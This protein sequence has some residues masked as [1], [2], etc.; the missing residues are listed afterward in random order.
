MTSRRRRIAKGALIAFA[1]LLSA[2]LLRAWIAQQDAPLSCRAAFGPQGEHNGYVQFTLQS[3]HPT[4]ELLEGEIFLYSPA[5]ENPPDHI[6]LTRAA[7]GA[8]ASS[9]LSSP[10]VPWSQGRAFR[11][12]QPF[13]IP[14]PGVSHRQFP[15]DNP[16]LEISVAFDPPLQ[17]KIVVIRN[18]S[19]AFIPV[20]E[21]LVANWRDPA[22]LDLSIQFKRNP[23]VQLSI[24]TVALAALI[25][26]LLL[27]RLRS[28]S[29]LSSAA[30]A[31]FFSVW[32]IRGVAE[33]AIL[34]FPTLL[35]LWLLMCILV[36]LFLLAWRAVSSR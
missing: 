5:T 2:C 34:S 19:G 22:T 30:A 32:S 17:P 12:P 10:L 31:Y 9:T 1:I 21:S 18:A 4:E 28:M 26:A 16:R 27:S 14:T 7:G 15:L 23:F 11:S 13:S 36:V 6:T 3:Q 20:C 33:P 8:F 24:V 25:F 35:D 29:D